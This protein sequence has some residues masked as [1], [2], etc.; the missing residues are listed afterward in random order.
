MSQEFSELPGLTLPFQQGDQLLIV[1]EGKTYRA[2]LDPSIALSNQS[3]AGIEWGLFQ[4]RLAAG[5]EGGTF[6][7]PDQ[8]LARP[9]NFKASSFGTINSFGQ[10]VLESGDYCF[11]GWSTGMEG[12]SMRGRFR[13]MNSQILWPSATTY[14][15]HYSWHIPIEGVFTISTQTTFVLEMQCDRNHAKPWGYGYGSDIDPEIY[16]SIMFF[17]KA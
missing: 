9:F 7:P 10:L 11:R 16:A 1:R 14:S 12:R 5:Q 8:W 3:G 15:L 6:H 4:I 17:R 2:T 13:S